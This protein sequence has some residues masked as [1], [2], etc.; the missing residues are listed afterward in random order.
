MGAKKQRE[1]ADKA[2]ARRRKAHELA[3]AQKPIVEALEQK[4]QIAYMETEWMDSNVVHGATAVEGAMQQRN[5]TTKLYK[6]LHVLYFKEIAIITALRAEIVAVERQL[7]RLKEA[8][9]VCHSTEMRKRDTE[10]VLWKKFYRKN[11]TRM[12]RSALGELLF[13]RWQRRA[14]EKA[15]GG[16]VKFWTWRLSVRSQYDLKYALELQERRQNT[17]AQQRHDAEERNIVCVHCGDTYAEAQNHERACRYHPGRYE[18]ACPRDCP[19]FSTKCMSHRA[20]RWTC[21]DLRE[22]GRHGKNG[23]CARFHM[24]PKREAKYD[25][26]MSEI[27]A[28]DKIENAFLSEQWKEIKKADWVTRA[29]VGK[30]RQLGSIREFNEAEREILARYKDLPN[31]VADSGTS[32]VATHYEN[33]RKVEE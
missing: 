24:P 6:I 26:V 4:R 31:K 13:G 29:R 30:Y 27:Q 8:K 32:K 18:V 22:E 9:Q 17:V 33:G 21:C 5:P 10:K 25:V 11:R 23:C 2:V 20:K 12:K 1:L 16:W 28:R 14:L 15:F 19:G 3:T 7:M